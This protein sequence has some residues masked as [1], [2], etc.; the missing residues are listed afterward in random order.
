MNLVASEISETV[1][2][3]VYLACYFN[4][5][6]QLLYHIN[7]IRDMFIQGSMRDVKGGTLPS[8]LQNLFARMLNSK[9]SYCDPSDVFATLNR[10][11]PDKIQL[12]DEY[13]LN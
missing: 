2:N 6:L 13:D 9:F 3:K 5:F 4:V 1:R 7:S 11:N 8:C 10:S 12:G